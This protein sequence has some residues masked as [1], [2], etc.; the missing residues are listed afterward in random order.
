MDNK[1][2]EVGICLQDL[3]AYN[4]GKLIFKWYDLECYNNFEEIYNEFIEYVKTQVDYT[5]DEIMI[6]DYSGCCNLGEYPDYADIDRLIELLS[7]YNIKA[8]NAYYNWRDNFIGFEE[9]YIGQCDSLSDYLY[10]LDGSHLDK[11]LGWLSCYFDWDSYAHDMEL[12]GVYYFE[13]GNL[14]YNN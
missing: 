3:R 7:D 4:E 13:D 2:I 9:C 6:A 5:P 8:I 1:D 14:F 12:N 10:D 11:Q